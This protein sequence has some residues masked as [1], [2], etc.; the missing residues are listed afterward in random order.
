M[1]KF[2]KEMIV[3]PSDLTDVLSRAYH[4]SQSPTIRLCHGN[5]K[6]PAGIDPIDWIVNYVRKPHFLLKYANPTIRDKHLP[7][8]T[9]IT[10]RYP[11]VY[12]EASDPHLWNMVERTIRPDG[13]ETFNI[14]CLEAHTTKG[15]HTLD[16]R[17][18]REQGEQPLNRFLTDRTV[19]MMEDTLQSLTVWIDFPGNPVVYTF[20]DFQDTGLR[21]SDDIGYY[22]CQVNTDVPF[23]DWYLL[24]KGP[25]KETKWLTVMFTHGDVSYFKDREGGFYKST[26]FE[27]LSQGTTSEFDM[28]LFSTIGRYIAHPWSIP[29]IS[30]LKMEEGYCTYLI[31]LDSGTQCDV[32][33]QP[34]DASMY[35]ESGILWACEG[36]YYRQV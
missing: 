15:T 31:D 29:Y 12:L 19:E 14:T 26:S 21:T 16:Y 8:G 28:E 9:I 30:S 33:Y 20:K 22:T 1:Y 6:T 11:E 34:S 18:S 35:S 10:D 7:T 36:E 24:G 3:A 32:L 25:K 2:V 5:D 17:H 23:P 4:E 13:F 27:G